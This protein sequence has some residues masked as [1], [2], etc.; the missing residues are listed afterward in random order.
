MATP[1]GTISLSD[2]NTELGLSATALITMNDAAVRTLAGVGGSG[3]VITMQDLQNKSNRVSIN[4]TI[5]SDTSNYVLNTAK[6]PG[7]SA[8]KTDMTLTIN[9]SV[10][11]FS[12]STGSYALTV[13]TS[14]NV[15]DTVTIVNN[16]VIVGR[17]GNGS[18]GATSSPARATPGSPGGPA[19]LVE[20]AITMNNLNRIAGGGGGGG[21]GNFGGVN[22]DKGFRGAGGGGG[23]GGVSFGSGGSGGFEPGGP[24]A[25]PATGSPGQTA[26]VTTAGAGGLGGRSLPASSGG[27]GG[28]YGST[29]GGGG[30]GQMPGAGPTGGSAG[31]CIVG[32]SNITYTNTGTR[33]GSIS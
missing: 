20:R 31:A 28:A 18:N 23:G 19:L 9:P 5:S 6:A 21:G 32:N 7:Y 24:G 12:S 10:N 16:G 11:V 4:V 22:L 29:G 27:S 14:W 17:G 8:G 25:N 15:S 30:V 26:T 13:D 2:V 1:S 3:T 33:N